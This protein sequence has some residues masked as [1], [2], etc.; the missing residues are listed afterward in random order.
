MSERHARL[1]LAGIA[2]GL[3]AGVL[4]GYLVRPAPEVLERVVEVG[5]AAQRAPTLEGRHPSAAAPAGEAPDTPAPGAPPA[6]EDASVIFDPSDWLPMGL[7]LSDART[8]DQDRSVRGYLARATLHALATRI[9][10]TGDELQAGLVEHATT[11]EVLDVCSLLSGKDWLDVVERLRRA[12]PEAGWPPLELARCA[13]QAGNGPWG[14]QVLLAELARNE[15]PSDDLVEAM[16]AH[17][18]RK[19]GALFL[20][21]LQGDPESLGVRACMAVVAGLREADATSQAAALLRILIAAHPFDDEVLGVIMEVDAPAGEAHAL[22]RLAE[23]PDD[24]QAWRTLA[25]LRTE[26]G[27]AAGALEAYRRLAEIQ[28][29]S[30]AL[31]HVI[32]ADPAL[33]LQLALRMAERSSDDDVLG[34][35][36]AAYL[37]IGQLEK[38]FETYQRASAAAPED[39]SWLRS[40]VGLDPARAAEVLAS[41]VEDPAISDEVVGAYGNALLESGRPADAFAQYERALR[42]D[43][44][45]YEWQIG[46]AR[47]DPTRAVPALTAMLAERG[48]EAT[49][50]TA[51]GIALIGSGRRDEGLRRMEDAARTG[52]DAVTVGELCK[53]DPVRGRAVLDGLLRSSPEAAEWHGVLGGLLVSE[54]KRAEA[55][56][57]Y[58]RAL[59][60]NPTDDEWQRRIAL[61]RAGR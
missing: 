34:A 53:V 46:M 45:D 32:V 11:D 42:A 4:L 22:R 47:A 37:G 2:A 36:G 14:W 5:R 55:I 56:A 58:E 39:F 12:V 27:D 17:D 35:L 61:L 3:L 59:A 43:P 41:R 18:A 9:P 7:G 24:V 44:G 49:F 23:R 40:L 8:P 50:G 16:V 13:R 54:G 51:L 38:A 31:R 1:H 57:A 6:G 19:A 20:A 33:G 15:T 52:P 26:R 25:S 28:P 60:L 21:R 29:D 48:D 10:E 30:D